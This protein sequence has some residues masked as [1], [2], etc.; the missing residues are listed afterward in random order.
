M[1][2]YILFITNERLGE[3]LGG[4]LRDQMSPISSKKQ[5]LAIKY[6]DEIGG[7]SKGATKSIP[8]EYY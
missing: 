8:E 7:L 3:R 1:S 2:K 5:S 4:E 6:Y